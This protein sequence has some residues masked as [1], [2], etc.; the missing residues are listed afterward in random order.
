MSQTGARAFLVIGLACVGALV[1]GTLLAFVVDDLW[2]RPEKCMLTIDLFGTG[3]GP[4]YDLTALEGVIYQAVIWG[5]PLVLVGG[6]LG[7]DV[8]Y[9]RYWDPLGVSPGWRLMQALAVFGG[10]AI[11]VVTLAVAAFVLTA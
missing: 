4:C 9:H 8:S 11:V 3:P 10:L 1:I 7:L 2:L 6:L 5:T